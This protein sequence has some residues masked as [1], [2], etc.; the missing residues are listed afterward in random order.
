MDHATAQ[1]W[2]DAYAHAWHTYDPDE[3]GALFTEDAV[4][5][6]DPFTE[7]LH[8]RDAIVAS[9]VNED[10]RDPAGTYSGHYEPVLVAR[11][12]VVANGRSR[13]FEADGTS[14]KAEYDNLFLLRFAEDGRCAESREWYMPRP[15][16]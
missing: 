9:W 1:R 15:K 10:T 16:Q 13:Y 5:H 7:P 3:I 12:R 2:L 8:G 6:Y 4:Y 14:F 11:D